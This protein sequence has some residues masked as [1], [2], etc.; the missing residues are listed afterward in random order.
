MA[1]NPALASEVSR[2]RYARLEHKLIFLQRRF[3]LDVSKQ[4]G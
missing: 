3:I 4:V 2:D 1:F